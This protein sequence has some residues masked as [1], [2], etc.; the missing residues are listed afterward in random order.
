[1]PKSL[2]SCNPHLRNEDALMRKLRRNAATSCAVE[3]M[4]CPE[5]EAALRPAR[6]AL[7][8]AFTASIPKI[9]MP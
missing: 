8:T 5:E 1:M 9:P 4:R 6:K 2:I 3:G 7:K